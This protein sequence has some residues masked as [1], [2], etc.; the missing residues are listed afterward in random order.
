MPP[1]GTTQPFSVR[2]GPWHTRVLYVAVLVARIQA[3]TTA[4]RSTTRP[5]S[6]RHCW[7]PWRL[8]TILAISALSTGLR[9]DELICLS[10][11]RPIHRAV[12]AFY[13]EIVSIKAGMR[14]AGRD[15]S[16]ARCVTSDASAVGR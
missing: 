8:G 9:H 3:S 15:A 2:P 5:H 11:E 4:S 10:Q 16:F 14:Q 1:A 13:D 12:E 6:P 7:T